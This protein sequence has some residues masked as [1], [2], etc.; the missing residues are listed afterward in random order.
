[1]SALRSYLASATIAC[2]LAVGLVAASGETSRDL[3]VVAA[4]PAFS[5]AL[6][7]T[8]EGAL[9]IGADLG[10]ELRSS[11]KGYAHLYVINA[12]GRV[13]LWLENIA[14]KPGK[15]LH[16]PSKDAVI[17][18]TPP[19]GEDQL[20]LLVTRAPFRGFANGPTDSPLNLK[21]SRAEFLHAFTEKKAKLVSGSWVIAEQSIRIEE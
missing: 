13:Q 11:V 20:F 17:R 16:Y 1:M 19:A 2:S 4:S 21:L 12:S 7:P 18:A 9:P 8:L 10:F 14:I 3:N 5:V 15:T 6:K